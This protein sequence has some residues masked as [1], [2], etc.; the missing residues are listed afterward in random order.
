MLVIAGSIQIDPARR[1]AAIAAAT[2]VMR[3]TRQEPGCISYTFSADLG[4]PGLFLLFEEWQDQAALD[5]HFK[6]PH[7]AR[8]Q[9]AI[10]GLG[11]KGMKIQRYVVESV[12]PL[13][14]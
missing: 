12:G 14:R 4:D 9:Q 1:E 5:R 11:V 3:E 13:G 6:T 2:E 8:F 10:A 7:M